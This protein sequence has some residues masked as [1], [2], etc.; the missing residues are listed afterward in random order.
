MS[1]A[2]SLPNSSHAAA[3]AARYG[4]AAPAA[5][6]PWNAHLDLLLSHRSVRGY[7]SDPLPAGGGKLGGGRPIGGDQFQFAGL[8]SGHGDRSA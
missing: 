4:A 2:E 8:V 3:L 6:G 1:I 7:R 5:E